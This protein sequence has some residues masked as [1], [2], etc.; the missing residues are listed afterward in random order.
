[1]WFNLIV[2][3][4]VIVQFS[5]L[6]VKRRYA[7]FKDLDIPHAEP[8]FPFGNIKSVN[9]IESL[10]HFLAKYY[11]QF[12]GQGP[13]A[14]IFSFF[15]PNTVVLDLDLVKNILVRDFEY[16]ENRGIYY[17]EKEDPLS[18]HLFSI[19]QPHWKLMR[20]KLTPTFT[21]GKMKYMYSTMQAVAIEF[22]QCIQNEMKVSNELEMK[23]ILARFTTDIIGSC[24]FGLECNSLADPNAV[25]RE[26]GRKVFG[27]PTL[28]AL[29]RVLI[30][31]YPNLG[32]KLGYKIIEPDVASFFEKC[33]Y[34][35]VEYRKK[36]DI[37]KNDFLNLLL[38]I[39]KD[40]KEDEL[41]I[42]EIAA[43]AFIF[44]LAGFE[45]SSTAMSFA[46]YE[47]SL[48]HQIQNKAREEIK[49]VLEKYDGQITYEALSEMKYIEQ[50]I[51]GNYLYTSPLKH[52]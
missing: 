9:R 21:S 38:E 11:N 4:F 41:T 46:L 25:F 26:M 15:A 51:N 47:L 18:A 33:V 31:V 52:F 3:V 23:D 48:N 29:E 6:F 49:T 44:F 35:T 13:I 27:K 42:P 28:N 7:F 36:N 19:D 43:Q 34:D 2:I 45:T 20:R 14:G 22:T 40:N 17:N 8:S 30:S 5:Y 37:V 39:G 1:M 12:K 10:S 32:R 16:F 50:I 24:A